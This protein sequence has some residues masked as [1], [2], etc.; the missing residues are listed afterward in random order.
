MSNTWIIYPEVR[1]SLWKHEVIPD[2]MVEAQVLVMK[3][4]TAPLLD[5]SAAH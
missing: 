2:D 1:D 4:A 3:G 5:E